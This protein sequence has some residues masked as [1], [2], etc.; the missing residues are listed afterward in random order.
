MS[1]EDNPL[2]L[3]VTEH[4]AE[5]RSRIMKAGYAIIFGM[6]ICYNFSEWLFDIVRYPIAPYLPA[7]GLVF[8]APADKFIAHLKLSFFGG[9]I[10][11]CPIWIYQLWS[12][13]A[14]GLYKKERNYSLGFI[15][16]GSL[17]FILGVLFAYYGVFPMAFKFLMGYG[18]SIDKPMI[19]IDQYLSFFVT[20]SLLFGL[21]FELPLVIVILGLMGVV[22]SKFLKEKRRYAIVILAMITAVITPPDPL[23]MIFMLVPMVLLYE[24]ALWI[25]W[26]FEKKRAG[27]N[28]DLVPYE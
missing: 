9:M 11:T 20:T 18:G 19:T 5:L 6:L 27:E 25:V 28:R 8:T 21:A 16:F 22:S 10:V 23:S 1:A 3:T 4:L 26:M 15:F 12:F 14:P 2:N 13:I 24:M 7:G 17:L